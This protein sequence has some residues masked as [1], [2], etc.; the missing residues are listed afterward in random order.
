MNYTIS[1]EYIIS[2]QGNEQV[3]HPLFGLTSRLGW[4]NMTN[5]SEH[6]FYISL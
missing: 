1:E 4:A 3:I 6:T 2:E 5:G